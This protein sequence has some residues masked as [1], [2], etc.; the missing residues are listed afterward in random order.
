MSLA[1][2]LVGVVLAGVV[3]L[4]AYLQGRHDGR[5]L[6]KAQEARDHEV[7]QLAADAAA[8]SAAAAISRIE[9]KHVL[10]RQVLETQV[11]EVPVFRDCVAPPDSMRRLN[12]ALTGD[13]S[14]ADT[15]EL[16]TAPA[17]G[18]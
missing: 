10:N 12:A 13:E 16:P 14:P 15:S 5:E 11:R 3:V 6:S 7:A 18:R 4:S 2:G 9:V 17:I 1:E 8:S